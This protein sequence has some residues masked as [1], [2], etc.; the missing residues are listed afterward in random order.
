M[1]FLGLSF[2]ACALLI[3]GLPP[4]SGFVGKFAM[5]SALLDRRPAACRGAPP[6]RGW[7]LV[8]RC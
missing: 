3:A 7:V 4:L 2:V 6:R 5:L 1:A 8:R